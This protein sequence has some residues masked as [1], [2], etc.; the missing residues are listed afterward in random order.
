MVYR[1]RWNDGKKRGMKEGREDRR[2]IVSI[3]V[4]EKTKGR[5]R[6]ATRKVSGGR[7]GYGIKGMRLDKL[8]EQGK[9]KSK[10]GGGKRN[11]SEG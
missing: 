10:E 8:K 9:E 7:R 2:K 6:E 11:I 1:I 3:G 5:R 4:R